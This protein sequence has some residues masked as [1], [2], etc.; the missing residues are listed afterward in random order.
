[1]VTMTINVTHKLPLRRQK[2]QYSLHTVC[3]GVINYPQTWAEHVLTF[4]DHSVD[5]R[6]NRSGE[7]G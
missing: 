1:M 2:V 3:S 7:F 5:T 4:V 6:I